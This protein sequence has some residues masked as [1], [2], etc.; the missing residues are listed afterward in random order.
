MFAELFLANSNTLVEWGCNLT[1]KYK[2]PKKER[3]KKIR[4]KEIDI[5]VEIIITLEC[6]QLQKKM[7]CF[8]CV[9]FH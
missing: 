2:I 5:K 9:C 3:K 8:F 6:L 7:C 4:N 1:Q